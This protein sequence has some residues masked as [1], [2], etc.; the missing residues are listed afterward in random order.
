MRSISILLGMALMIVALPG[1]HTAVSGLPVSSINGNVNS[2]IGALTL[3]VTQPMDESI[4]RSNPITVSGNTKPGADIIINE[5]SVAVEN[6]HFSAS[7]ELEP[8]PNIIDIAA[9]DSYGKE[10]SRYITVIYVP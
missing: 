8:G 3:N 6:G 1:C 4:V 10:A 7:V 2:D 9:R 5:I